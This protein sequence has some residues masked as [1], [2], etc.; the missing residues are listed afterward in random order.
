MT[1]QRQT[2][3]SLTKGVLFESKNSLNESAYFLTAV[4]ETILTSIVESQNVL[5]LRSEAIKRLMV[6]LG[7]LSSEL[8]IYSTNPHNNYQ[9]NQLL[10]GIKECNSRLK[11]SDVVNI[12]C[13]EPQLEEAED[14][15]LT[16]EEPMDDECMPKSYEGEM[17]G[18]PLDR[19]YFEDGTPVIPPAGLDGGGGMLQRG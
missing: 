17:A 2:Y 10:N 15:C 4:G 14:C 6:E 1:L 5:K 19:E 9:V 18:M 7:K 3:Q 8:D 11:R 12:L 16:M 13:P